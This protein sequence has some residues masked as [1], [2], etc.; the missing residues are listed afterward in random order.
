MSGDSKDA[1]K[2]CDE[3]RKDAPQLFAGVVVEVEAF[4]ST[5]AQYGFRFAEFRSVAARAT[6]E[7]KLQRAL[8]SLGLWRDVDTLVGVSYSDPMQLAEGGWTLLLTDVQRRH[9]IQEMFRA[10]VRRLMVDEL[11]SRIVSPK[12]AIRMPMYGQVRNPITKGLHSSLAFCHYGDGQRFLRLMRLVLLE[13][14]QWAWLEREDKV[15]VLRPF[16]RTLVS[17]PVLGWG[18]SRGTGKKVWVYVTH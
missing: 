15:N 12:N 3:I 6:A 11:E 4:I 8:C 17:T 1:G 18:H 5:V 13:Y 9:Y 2:F 10:S 7:Q 16:V 14:V